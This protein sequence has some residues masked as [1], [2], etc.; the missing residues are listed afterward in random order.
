[1]S[2]AGFSLPTVDHDTITIPFPDMFTLVEHL[3]GP[4]NLA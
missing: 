1:M 4:E 3:Q 2:S